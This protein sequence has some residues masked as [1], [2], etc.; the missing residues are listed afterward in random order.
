MEHIEIVNKLIGKIEPI[1]ESNIDDDR[2]VNLAN[3]IDLM[4]ELH[5]QI[6]DIAFYNKDRQ[7]YSMN[8]AG[9][10]AN[11]YLDYLGIKE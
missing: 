8:R 5:K 3:M 9:K 11:D 10:Y 6:D 4:K 7:E 2:F 1:G